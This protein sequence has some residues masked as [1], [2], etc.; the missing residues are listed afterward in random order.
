VHAH[1][2][3]ALPAALSFGAALPA[4]PPA[5]VDSARAALLYVSNRPE[6]HPQADFAAQLRDAAPA[7]R[8]AAGA[9]VRA[10]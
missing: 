3:R 7:P 6:D 9:A 5:P 1:L 2:P 10:P 8:P 4:Q